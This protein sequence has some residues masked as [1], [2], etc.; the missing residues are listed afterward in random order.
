MGFM[1]KK[2]SI[3]LLTLALGLYA[4]KDALLFAWF[5]LDRD[6]FTT[7]L[8]ENIDRPELECH[9]KCQL[10]ELADD[11]PLEGKA[12]ASFQL[13]RM[14]ADFFL[15]PTVK[16]VYSP[17]AITRHVLLPDFPSF[18]DFLPLQDIFRP[19]RLPMPDR[20]TGRQV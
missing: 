4:L 15:K 18:Y 2:A 10:P 7:A 9:G 20:R 11:Q 14:A 8:C 12:S 1:I 16:Y 5:E 3:L 19:P 6:S 17:G 13:P